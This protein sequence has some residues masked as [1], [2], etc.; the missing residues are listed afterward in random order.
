VYA[1]GSAHDNGVKVCCPMSALIGPDEVAAENEFQGSLVVS[2]GSRALGCSVV[3]VDAFISGFDAPESS[4]PDNA[5]ARLG[6]ELR[7]ELES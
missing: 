1:I 2:A 4:D 5:W 3:D 7:A 6:Q